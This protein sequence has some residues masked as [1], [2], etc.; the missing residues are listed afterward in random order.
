MTLQSCNCCE[1][2]L[3]KTE[4]TH[5][6]FEILHRWEAN[7]VEISRETWADYPI[8][9]ELTFYQ[10][11]RCH[12]G[13]FLPMTVGS[14]AFYTDITRNEYYLTERWD[15]H[16]AIKA[17]RSHKSSSV[18]DVGCGQGAFLN[19][20]TQQ[21]PTVACHGNDSNPAVQG[22]LPPDAHLHVTL[23]DAPTS[24]DAVTLFQVIE[25]VANP[26]E[27]LQASLDKVRP[28]GLV[29]V[30]VPDHSGPI[31][32]FPDSHTAIPPHHVSTWTPKSLEYLM[33][34]LGLT[35]VE[36]KKEPLPDYLM[37]YYL[38]KMLAHWLGVSGNFAREQMLSKRVARPIIDLCKKLDIKSL[39]LPG[40][41]YLV[42]AQKPE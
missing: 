16:V 39:P 6:L 36:R 2:G 31:R 5:C 8:N 41:T 9:T 24:L 38:P 25:H 23:S 40:H 4:I 3:K 33:H 34:R 42:V 19:L 26:A 37:P 35:V 20:V 18:L 29:I 10:C 1:S 17:M 22:T 28:G 12:F 7:G 15:F 21:L 14:D 27:L 30:S 13:I 32:F 11:D